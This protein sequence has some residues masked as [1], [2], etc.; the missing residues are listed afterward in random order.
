MDRSE[1]QVLPAATPVP[2]PSG[3]PRAE[4][5]AI[6]RKGFPRM[7]Q[8]YPV[9]LPYSWLFHLPHHP[10]LVQFLSCFPLVQIFMDRP[11]LVTSVL[12]ATGQS[13]NP[14]PAPAPSPTSLGLSGV[15]HSAW[16][17]LCA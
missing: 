11:S 5:R 9:P 14:S 10:S 1:D 13:A 8:G 16:W 3:Y 17:A 15:G 4:N 2:R 7:S 6:A 12:Q